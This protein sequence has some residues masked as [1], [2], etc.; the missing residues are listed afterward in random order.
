MATAIAHPEVFR[1]DS[2]YSAALHVGSLVFVS[3]AIPIDGDGNLVGPNDPDAQIRQVLL[4]IRRLLESAGASV[5]NL[6]QVTFYLADMT[7]WRATA[8][9]R[10]EFFVEPYPATTTVEVA[11]LVNTDWLIEIDAIAVLPDD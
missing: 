9:A 4:N 2:P 10:R 3:G 7:Q 8:E 1:F 5:G 6:A 11:R